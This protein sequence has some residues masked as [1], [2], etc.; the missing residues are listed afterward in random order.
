MRLCPSSTDLWVKSMKTIEIFGDPTKSREYKYLREGCRGIIIRDGK[1]LLSYEREVDQYLIPG[2]GLEEGE[3]LVN[4]CIRELAEE[5]GAVVEPQDHYLLLEEFYNENYFKSH[6]FVCELVGEC[7][8]HLTDEEMARGLV[9]V[10]LDFDQALK[11]FSDYQKYENTD[12]M[13]YG[14]YYREMLALLEYMNLDK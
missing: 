11:I 7:Q 14:A 9:P 5:C 2:G 1:I 3:S 12:K 13:R 6:Y 4:C 10:W 8:N